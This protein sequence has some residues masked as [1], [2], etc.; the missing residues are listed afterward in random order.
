MRYSLGSVLLATGY[1]ALVAG[2]IVSRSRF[3]A[4]VIW[5]LTF[6]AV[7]YAI[8]TAFVAQARRRAMAIGFSLFAAGHFACLFAAESRVP[9][10]QVIS[11]AGYQVR[12][13]YLWS[14]I[15]T[16]TTTNADGRTRQRSRRQ[17]IENSQAF[18]RSSNAVGTML[19]GLIGCGIGALAY[20]HSA[21]AINL[22]N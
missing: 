6:T 2:A 20:R 3:M 9:M 4:D 1:V 21:T 11:L 12:D 5:A 8:I 18:V 15:V 22:Q 13:G 14:P 19:A 17:Q 7:C 16:Y 10:N